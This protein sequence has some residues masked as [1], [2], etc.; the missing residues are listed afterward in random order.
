M[1][2]S[3]EMKSLT[4]STSE[5]T[6]TTM[7]FAKILPHPKGQSRTVSGMTASLS[8][9]PLG[10]TAPQN[11]VAQTTGSLQDL[12]SASLVDDMLSCLDPRNASESSALAQTVFDE[13]MGNDLSYVSPTLSDLTLVNSPP[14]M[15]ID[16]TSGD[17]TPVA[18]GSPMLV[19]LPRPEK[20]EMTGTT[21]SS[22]M[23]TPTLSD[24]L[25]S[26]PEPSSNA[27]SDYFSLLAQTLQPAA[28]TEVT[29]TSAVDTVA[30]SMVQTP[31]ESPQYE[32]TIRKRQ[33]DFL[34]S[35]PP[36][37][38]LKRR[39]TSSSKR[40]AKLAETLA[41]SAETKPAADDPVALKRQKN[42]DAARRSRMR[43]M[44]RIDTL[45]SRV[46]ELETE[47]NSLLTKV[48]VLEAEKAHVKDNEAGLLE[49]IRA[50]ESQL[51]TAHCALAATQSFV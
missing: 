38:A 51:N 4:S 40:K 46:V 10:T 34:S 1:V 23:T 33:S 37:I 44:L 30:P 29:S 25:F 3:P 26:C 6:T 11:D 42:T 27:M 36:E 5:P 50:L 24:F 17:S 15:S 48:A 39:R 31:K 21:S 16:P 2:V 13:W 45:E 43:K 9:A 14:A 22:G 41:S 32:E 49:R 35:L 12:L 18:N 28:T 7:K 8:P 20:V 19:S 47:N